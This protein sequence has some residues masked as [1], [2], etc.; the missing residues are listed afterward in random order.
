MLK[1][2]TLRNLILITLIAILCGIIS[3]GAS[4]LYNVLVLVLTPLGLKP[5]ANEA[6]LGLWIISGPLAAEVCRT[7]G[8]AF[9]SEVLTAVV[10]IFLDDQWG[11][12]NLITGAIQGAGTEA[13]FALTQYRYNWIG[14]STAALTGTIIT[15]GYD[16]L[17]LGYSHYPLPLLMG[18][19]IVRLLSLLIISSWLPG[20]VV[21]MLKK[22]KVI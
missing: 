1:H 13:G 20:R 5:F 10:E 11:V 22:T 9:F 18:L 4:Y 16:L 6:L 21:K 17:S 19:F 3:W 12:I 14:L 15:F 7:P 2:W 8:A